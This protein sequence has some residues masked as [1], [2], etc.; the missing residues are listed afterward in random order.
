MCN[1][2]ARTTIANAAYSFL[3][4]WTQKGNM[5]VRLKKLHDSALAR[6]DKSKDWLVNTVAQQQ[7]VLTGQA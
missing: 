3:H 6:Y 4:P 2:G 1:T 5:A 7:P